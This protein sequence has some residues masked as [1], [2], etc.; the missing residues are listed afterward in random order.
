M[1]DIIIDKS[2]MI[3]EFSTITDNKQVWN[4]YNTNLKGDSAAVNFY[5]ANSIMYNST[6]ETDTSNLDYKTGNNTINTT[7]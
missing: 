5:N 7:T 2:G 6:T 1:G 4:Y 3:Y